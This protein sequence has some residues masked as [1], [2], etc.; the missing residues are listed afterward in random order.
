MEI[1]RKNLENRLTAST[2]SL[3]A[4]YKYRGLDKYQAWDKY[5]QDK[6]LKPEVD[7]KEFYNVFERC[8]ACPIDHNQTIDFTATHFDN[9]LGINCQITRDE[10][11]VFKMLWEDG[12][13]GSYP[14]CHE[15]EAER[16][17]EI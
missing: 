6:A 16:Y 15:P 7:A 8:I 3:A 9:F 2:Y 12:H 11:G 10:H 5:I 4:E 1:T 13:T 14:P 17:V